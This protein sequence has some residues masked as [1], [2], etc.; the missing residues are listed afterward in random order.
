[1]DCFLRYSCSISLRE[2]KQHIKT[3]LVNIFIHAP[4]FLAIPMREIPQIYSGHVPIFISRAARSRILQNE[5][6]QSCY[7]SVFPFPPGPWPLL[8]QDRCP[9]HELAPASHH[10][11]APRQSHCHHHHHLNRHLNR[12]S[13]SIRSL[14]ISKVTQ[15]EWVQATFTMWILHFYFFIRTSKNQVKLKMFLGFFK[16]FKLYIKNVL[17][18]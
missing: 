9:P 7:P 12:P 3:N 17:K 15:T 5:F 1:M 8:K 16:E 18:I 2:L 4:K 13:W 10:H 6:T 11:H 14:K